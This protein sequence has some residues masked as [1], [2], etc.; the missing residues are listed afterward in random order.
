MM[1]AMGTFTILGNRVK[2]LGLFV[3]C[4][5]IKRKNYLKVGGHEVVKG[6]VVEDLAIGSRLRK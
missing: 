3:P 4:I 1:G 6:E 5:V 2:P